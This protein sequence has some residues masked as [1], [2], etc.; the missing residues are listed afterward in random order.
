MDNQRIR[1]HL[2]SAKWTTV[3]YV[4]FIAGSVYALGYVAGDRIYAMIYLRG[5]IPHLIIGVS[6]VALGYLV[7]QG[8]QIAVSRSALFELENFVGS[9]RDEIVSLTK[10]D[11]GSP[12]DLAALLN[13]LFRK[14]P[15]GRESEMIA[16][17]LRDWTESG[18]DFAFKRLEVLLDLESQASENS[19]KIP[20]VL[21]WMAPMLGF[22]GT[23]WGIAQSLGNFTGFMGDVDN[24]SRI[25]DGLGTIT[26]GLGIAFDT[27][28]LGLFFAILITGIAAYLQRDRRGQPGQT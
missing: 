2:L 26:A 13:H 22:L 23:V 24:I 27:T 21:G 11:Q 25:K 16:V 1:T 7:S 10:P 17:L 3:L 19:F 8:I 5:F 12:R 15:E 6:A 14:V 9:S 18:Q 4:A 20:S 28:L